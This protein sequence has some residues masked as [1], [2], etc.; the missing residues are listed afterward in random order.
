MLQISGGAGVDLRINRRS[1][2]Q[3]A[4]ETTLQDESDVMMKCNYGSIPML[5]YNVTHVTH[6]DDDDCN[7]FR[8]VHPLA[9][10]DTNLQV[11]ITRTFNTSK[12]L[13]ITHREG[14]V[15]YII[16]LTNN[17]ICEK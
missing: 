10:T 3:M 1:C 12:N 4:L 7:P 6:I 9:K 13:C 15:L 5:Q 8:P 2:P 14:S 16:L 17:W 11:Q